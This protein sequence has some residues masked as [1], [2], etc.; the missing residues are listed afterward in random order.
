MQ[1]LWQTAQQLL[2]RF[3]TEPSWDPASPLTGIHPGE[4]NTCPQTP[5]HGRSQHQHSQEGRS[6][7]GVRSTQ[8][9]G[10]EQ[11]D[12]P[13]ERSTV[14]PQ[15]E[16][17]PDT[18]MI[19]SRGKTPATEYHILYSSVDRKCPEPAK[20]RQNE[21]VVT[22]TRGGVRLGSGEVPNEVRQESL[23]RAARAPRLGLGGS[24]A[25][26]ALTRG[27]QP[28]S[29]ALSAGHRAHC[30]AGLLLGEVAPYNPQ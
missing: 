22:E 11:C 26:C 1:P 8:W 29:A 2:K 23:L 12:T 28:D 5:A 10:D 15:K 6:G 17:S 7:D 14:Q 13:T 20:N 21:L 3:D 19:C 24:G 9:W 16:P 18:D 4:L 25:A 30:P 27:E